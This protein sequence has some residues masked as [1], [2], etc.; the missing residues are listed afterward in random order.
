MS[1]FEFTT[2]TPT[3]VG[4]YAAFAYCEDRKDTKPSV[5][6]WDGTSFQHVS[7][8]YDNSITHFMKLN[9]PGEEEVDN[10]DG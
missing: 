8:W 2:G 3:E 10:T 5:Y 1:A 7:G 6:R 4:L 9:V